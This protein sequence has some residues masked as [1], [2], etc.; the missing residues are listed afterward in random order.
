MDKPLEEQSQDVIQDSLAALESLVKSPGWVLLVEHIDVKISLTSG[1]LAQECAELVDILKKE[2]K[3]GTI[4]G[5]SE[6]AFAPEQ[7][8]EAYKLEL[9]TRGDPDD[10]IE[11]E[12]D[13]NGSK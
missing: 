3:S 13:G 2:F 12:S 5:Y 11:G 6:L 8:M 1:G 4:L 9:K 10:E 7:L